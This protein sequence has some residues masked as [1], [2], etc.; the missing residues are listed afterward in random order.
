MK[1]SNKFIRLA[2]FSEKD[3]LK[4]DTSKLSHLKFED[5]V[6]LVLVN[7]PADCNVQNIGDYLTGYF[8]GSHVVVISTDNPLASCENYDEN[9][10]NNTFKSMMSFDNDERISIQAFSS[11]IFSNVQIQVIDN[12]DE[13]TS[14][15]LERVDTI[16]NNQIYQKLDFPHTSS[17]TFCLLYST[18]KNYG[19]GTSSLALNK[20]YNNNIHIIGGATSWRKNSSPENAFD[21]IYY[22]NSILLNNAIAIFCKLKEGLAFSIC[23]TEATNYTNLKFKISSASLGFLHS[24]Y[25]VNDSSQKSKVIN[26]LTKFFN[27][28]SPRDLFL[29]YFQVKSTQELMQ[30]LP[31]VVTENGPE[32]KETNPTAILGFLDDGSAIMATNNFLNHNKVCHLLEMRDIKNRTKKSWD[33]YIRN[34][35]M[36]IG[37]I[38]IDCISRSILDKTIY[39]DYNLW[40]DIPVGG[41][42]SNAEMFGI[43]KNG[44]SIGLMFYD[45]STQPWI[46]DIFLKELHEERLSIIEQQNQIINELHTY[47]EADKE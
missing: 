40:Q 14:S 3:L 7:L 28:K 2:T 6:A 13:Q 42:I 4:R 47:E 30:Y 24:I 1:K 20:L 41:F 23:L 12:G 46:N 19:L 43:T 45:I 38:L 31:L 17:D 27:A 11:K 37:G 9:M 5:G 22:Q 32:E 21:F 29:D 26:K 10:E 16:I 15:A 36:P 35:I 44:S 33:L 34:K 39:K 18:S 25:E 8:H